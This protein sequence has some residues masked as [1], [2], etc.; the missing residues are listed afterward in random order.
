M[1]RRPL[2]TALAVA[3]A[4]L[5]LVLAA[6]GLVAPSGPPATENAT[7]VSAGPGPAPGTAEGATPSPDLRQRPASGA[8]PISLDI[9][10]IGVSTPVNDVG[11]N[12]DGTLEVPAPG[13][14]YDQ[15]AWYRGS[16]TPGRVGPSVIIGHVDSAA[17][18]PSVFYDLGRLRPGDRVTVTV[19][20]RSVRA[21][22]VGSVR[23]VPKD[24]FP[25]L[26]V[27]GDTAGPELRLITCSGPF[28]AAE[29]SY[30]DNTVVFARLVP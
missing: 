17:D 12:P 27:Y 19:A 16:P 30:E 1:R 28:D 7:A 3:L 8:A 5:G 9:P 25:R 24:A 23:R 4:G 2:L 13:P 26:E 29:R 15:A 18:G 11:L 20:D 22:E 10:A 6:V 14:Q 21:F